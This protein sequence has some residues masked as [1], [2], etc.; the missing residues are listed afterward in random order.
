MY[1]KHVTSEVNLLSMNMKFLILSSLEP[2]QLG[3][4]VADLCRDLRRNPGVDKDQ[5][6]QGVLKDA[7]AAAA[8]FSSNRQ[9][10]LVLGAGLLR[11]HE[12]AE[13]VVVAV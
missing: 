4:E 7:V 12:V 13:A 9:N 1:G 5:L 2:N 3:E 8:H 11:P 10:L 6:C